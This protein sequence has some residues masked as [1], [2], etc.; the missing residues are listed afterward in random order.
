MKR[1]SKLNKNRV[2]KL[3]GRYWSGDD[4]VLSQELAKRMTLSRATDLFK[5][6]E[7]VD[8]IDVEIVKIGNE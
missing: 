4:W 8:A 5:V 6:L 1:M 3:I 7:S 2:I